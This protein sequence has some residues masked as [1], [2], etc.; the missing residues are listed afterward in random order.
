M[1][2]ET[3][4]GYSIR[5]LADSLGK[6]RATVTRLVATIPPCSGTGSQKRWR[7]GDVEAALAAKPGKSLRDEKLGEEI[8]RLRI[9]NDKDEAKVI[10]KA[11][12]GKACARLLSGASPMLEQKLV[13]EW[14]SAVAGLDVPAARVFGRRMVD[15][16]LA[17]MRALAMEFPE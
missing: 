17:G 5:M 4:P 14:P 10:D 11:V 12:V 16:I 13:N 1:K 15:D 3:Q 6:D 2:T 8:R 9:R 7:L